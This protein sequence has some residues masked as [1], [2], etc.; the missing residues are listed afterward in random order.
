MK[1]F[2]FSTYNSIINIGTEKCS[3][4]FEKRRVR[5]VNIFLFA[6]IWVVLAFGVMNVILHLPLL[7]LIDVFLAFLLS[8]GFL[9]NKFTQRNINKALILVVLPLYFMVFPLF[10]GNIGTEYYNFVFLIIGF[11]IVDKRLHL[12]L[13]SI[14]IM[15]LFI[16]SKYLINTV[17]YPPIYEVLERVHYYPS[18]IASVLIIMSSIALFKF[19]TENYQKQIIEDQGVLANQVL[20]LNEKDLFNK[21]LLNELNHRVKNNLQLIS[22]LFTLQSYQSKNKEVLGALKDAQNRLD[23]IMILHQHL[24]S[25]NLE[26]EPSLK[27]FIGDLITYLQQGLAPDKNVKV[28]LQVDAIKLPTNVA[29]HIGLIVNELFTNALKYGIAKEP[30]QSFISVQI[31]DKEHAIRIYVKD[32]GPGF[33][34]EFVA[35]DSASFGMELISTIVDQY[36]GELEIKNREGAEVKVILNQHF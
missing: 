15:S 35:R 10:F 34:E 31:T 7:V 16:Y 28:D 11:Y 14:F 9:L 25:N 3:S 23:T 18:V 13:L 17:E 26:I 33:P 20:K 6:S 8:I 30:E 29:V 5:I 19:D 12:V 32:S 1:I 21:S 27:L 4:E 22:G 2:I 36:E 24:Y